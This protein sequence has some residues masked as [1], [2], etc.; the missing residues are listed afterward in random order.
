M[1]TFH[2]IFLKKAIQAEREERNIDYIMSKFVVLAGVKDSG[3]PKCVAEVTSAK[4]IDQKIY[5]RVASRPV[6][7]SE[8]G[9]VYVDRTSRGSHIGSGIT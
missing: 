3:Y 6:N 1:G 9:N 8:V 2:R 5:W 4:H 7:Y